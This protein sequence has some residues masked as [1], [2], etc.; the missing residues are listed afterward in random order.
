MAY[1]QHTSATPPGPVAGLDWV[2]AA[3]AYATSR[4]PPHKLV[5]GIP[6]YG[7]EWVATPVGQISRSLDFDSLSSILEKPGVEEQ[8]DEAQ[9]SPW[10]QFREEPDTHTAWYDNRRSF[11]E[12]LALVR[13]FGLRGVAAWRLGFEQPEFWS[14][15]SEWAKKE[16]PTSKV[17]ASKSGKST[18]TKRGTR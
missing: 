9:H 13:E 16:K 15:V 3:L 5:L 10:L 12:K 4:I 11:E 18:R 7:R 8:W 17:A 2:R 6:L 1:D 14:T